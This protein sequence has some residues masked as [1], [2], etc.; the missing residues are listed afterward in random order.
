MAPIALGPKHQDLLQ[1][2]IQVSKTSGADWTTIATKADYP[3]SKYARD[4]WALVKSKLLATDNGA[5]INLAD[6]QIALLE[7]TLEVMKTEVSFRQQKHC[8]LDNTLLTNAVQTDWENVASVANVKTSKYARDQFAIIR[9]KLCGSG[10]AKSDTAS[11]SKTP[12]KPRGVKA[13]QPRKRKKR[14]GQISLSY[15]FSGHDHTNRPRQTD[16]DDDACRPSAS[17]DETSM[18]KAKKN[19]KARKVKVEEAEAEDE[20]GEEPVARGVQEQQAD[21]HDADKLEQE[22]DTQEESFFEAEMFH[23]D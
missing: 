12:T 10:K 15:Y 23:M 19:K 3:T 11:P 6:R 18:P 22:S 17:A 13:T 5:Q 7:A 8:G 21:A 2:Y 1:A 4:Q 14:E 16:N 9:N 20:G